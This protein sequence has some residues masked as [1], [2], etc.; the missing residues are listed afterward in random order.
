MAT[1]VNHQEVVRKLIETKAIDFKAIGQT[2]AELGP[3]AALADEPWEV[4]CGTMRTFLRLYV[5]NPGD[6]GQVANLSQLSAATTVLKG[7]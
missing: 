4:F 2:I 1:R 3:A 6:V 7:Q 5:I